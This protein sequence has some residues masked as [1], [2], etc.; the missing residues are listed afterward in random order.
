MVFVR[1]T[2]KSFANHLQPYI[3][4][5]VIF[6]TVGSSLDLALMECFSGQALDLLHSFQG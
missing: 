5:F 6:L 4:T 1:F 3:F 2:Y